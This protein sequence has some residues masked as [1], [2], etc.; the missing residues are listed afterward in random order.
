ML[1]RDSLLLPFAH[2]PQFGAAEYLQ[3]VVMNCI[4]KWLRT[5]NQAFFGEGSGSQELFLANSLCIPESLN[6]SRPCDFL[7]V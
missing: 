4:V 5:F 7:G 3:L 1:E 2:T 6:C